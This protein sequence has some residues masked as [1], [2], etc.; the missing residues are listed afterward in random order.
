MTVIADAPG[1]QGAS[2]KRLGIF[3]DYSV[4]PSRKRR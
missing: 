2:A 4:H 1:N 3:P